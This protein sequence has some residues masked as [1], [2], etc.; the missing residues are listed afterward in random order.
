[1]APLHL[2]PSLALTRAKTPLLTDFPITSDV[3]SPL[4]TGPLAPYTVS[5]PIC[6]V[7]NHSYGVP[8]LGD[9]SGI[10]ASSTVIKPAIARRFVTRGTQWPARYNLSNRIET[11]APFPLAAGVTSTMCPSIREPFRIVEPFANG[12]SWAICP[13][14]VWSGLQF[15][16][17]KVVR[18]TT[19]T[20]VPSRNFILISSPSGTAGDLGLL[21]NGVI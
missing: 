3:F 15:S 19:G 21:F 1:M 2:V 9:S 13:R 11:F 8:S 20:I 12:T 7:G 18:R 16:K 17:E 4:I 5:P 6:V 10:L 14:R